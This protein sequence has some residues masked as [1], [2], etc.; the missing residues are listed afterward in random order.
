LCELK[1][2]IHATLAGVI[3]AAAIPKHTRR[4]SLLDKTE[5]SL[6]PWVSLLILPVFAFANAGVSL[7]DAGVSGFLQPVSIGA[8]LGLLLGKPVGIALGIGVVAAVGWATIP[9]DVTR[10]QIVGIAAL[11][12]IGF[13]MSLL[14]AA[15]AFEAQAPSLFQEAKLG[16]LAGSALSAGLG[17]WLLG[18]TRQRRAARTA[19]SSSRGPE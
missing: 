7:G 16:I 12:G 18:T 2:G 3:T 19:L 6:V 15:L 5:H 11:C 13:T 17:L 14:L 1:S 10:R 9:P 8:A 4:G